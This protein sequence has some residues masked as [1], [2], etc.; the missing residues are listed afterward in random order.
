[1]KPNT[2]RGHLSR[3]RPFG[4]QG[5]VSPCRHHLCERYNIDNVEASVGF[6]CAHLFSSQ[7]RAV[8]RGY[9]VPPERFVFAWISGFHKAFTAGGLV[10]GTRQDQARIGKY[11]EGRHVDETPG[12]RQNNRLFK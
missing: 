5:I 1:M 4:F 7:V 6:W 8:L 9:V 11:R 12:P 3:P 10:E 2:N